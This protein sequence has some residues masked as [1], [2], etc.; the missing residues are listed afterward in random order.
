[1][2]GCVS[3]APPQPEWRLVWSDEFDT[4]PHPSAA[5]WG[6]DVGG[7]GWGN[8]E[9]QYY[10]AGRLQNARLENGRLVIEAHR[11]AFGGHAFTSARLVTRGRAD[12]RYGRIEVRA[13]LPRARGT[14]PAFWMLP[15]ASRY[16]SGAWPETGEIDLLEHV[17]HDPNVV[18]STVHTARYNHVLGTQRLGTRVLPTATTDFHVYALEWE[19]DEIRAYVDDRLHFS[20]ANERRLR[21]NATHHEWPFDHPFYLV[22]NLAVGGSLGGARGVDE[23]VWPQRL[24]VEYVRVYQRTGLS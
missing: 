19:A 12:W 18:F 21:A 13:R 3:E 17:G 24:E 22:L 6:Y 9:A 5:H 4:G 11:E 1:M 10:T 7:G 8:D 23:A 15:T 2:S 16:G 20:F 14:W